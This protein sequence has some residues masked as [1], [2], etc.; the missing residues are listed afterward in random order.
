MTLT[1]EAPPAGSD[2][3]SGRVPDWLDREVWDAAQRQCFVAGP[4]GFVDACAARLTEL[5]AAAT[6]IQLDSFLSSAPA[7][8]SAG[9]VP[10]A[11]G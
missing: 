7:D 9:V 3:L 10:D 4:P 8:V 6:Q 5:G 2:W 11:G 1:R